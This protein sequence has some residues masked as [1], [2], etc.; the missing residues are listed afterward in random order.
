MHL[1]Y[2]SNNF[3][4]APWKSSCL[5]NRAP[6]N[7]LPNN[8]LIDFVITYFFFQIFSF[9]LNVFNFFGFCTN[10]FLFFQSFLHYVLLQFLHNLLDCLLLFPNFF[11]STTSYLPNPSARTGYHTSSIFK[12]SLTGLNSEFSI[13]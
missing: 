1:L 6:I 13:S 12:R 2:R 4:K 7:L 5:Y 10:Y 8:N 9:S 3:R 11:S